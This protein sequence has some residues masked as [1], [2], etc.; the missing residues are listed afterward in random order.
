MGAGEA[1]VKTRHRADASKIHRKTTK[2]K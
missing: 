1:T 2:R